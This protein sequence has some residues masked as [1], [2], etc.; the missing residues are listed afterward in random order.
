MDLLINGYGFTNKCDWNF[1]SI[2]FVC[3][4]CLFICIWLFIYLMNLLLL[5]TTINN[6]RQMIIVL[7]CWLD[8]RTIVSCTLISCLDLSLSVWRILIYGNDCTDYLPRRRSQKWC[9]Y[10]TNRYGSLKRSISIVKQRYE[11]TPWEMF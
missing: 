7:D 3:W 2:F 4:I 8:A 1:S 6:W 9:I 10:S 5:I 11:R